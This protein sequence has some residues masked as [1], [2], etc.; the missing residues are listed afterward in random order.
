[1]T[2]NFDNIGS[3]SRERTVTQNDMKY[4]TLEEAVEAAI[5]LAT[6]METLV[7]ITKEKCGKYQLFGNGEIVKVIEVA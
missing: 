7:K 5:K 6:D 1:M 2:V 3:K 4:E